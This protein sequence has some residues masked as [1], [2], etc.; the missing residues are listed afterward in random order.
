M[1]VR[2]GSLDEALQVLQGVDELGQGRTHATYSARLAGRR[3]LVLVAE[4]GGELVGFK[5]GYALDR[6]RFYSWVGGIHPAHRRQGI[7]QALLDTQQRWASAQGYGCIEVKTSQ[8]FP[9]M[10]ALLERNSYQRLGE[11]EG[12]LLYRRAL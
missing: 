5:V 7:A 8:A 1:L 9:Q 2:I 6:R 3:H 10:V 12:K 4:Q 11:V